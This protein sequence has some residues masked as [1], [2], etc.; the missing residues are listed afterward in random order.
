MLPNSKPP[1]DRELSKACGLNKLSSG[2]PPSSVCKVDK[3]CNSYT[4]LKRKNMMSC[5]KLQAADNLS[6]VPSH[7]HSVHLRQASIGGVD[8]STLSV[9]AKTSRRIGKV[10]A[11]AWSSQVR[12]SACE[13]PRVADITQ[14]EWAQARDL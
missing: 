8:D 9:N 13:W 5:V 6:L 11:D 3:Y 10:F 12:V 14:E 2:E 4:I 1:K 7:L